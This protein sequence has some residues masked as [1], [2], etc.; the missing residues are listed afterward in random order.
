MAAVVAD[1][2]AQFGAASMAIANLSV[3]LALAWGV[4]ARIRAAWWVALVC[5]V[6]FPVGVILGVVASLVSDSPAQAGTAP[7]VFLGL[8]P[9]VVLAWVALTFALCVASA[10]AL[11]RPAVRHTLTFC[12]APPLS[13]T[14]RSRPAIA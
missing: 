2:P 14:G 4:R 12:A 3:F 10:I 11:L 7:A 9:E 5:V 6:L 8:G 13:R 1:L